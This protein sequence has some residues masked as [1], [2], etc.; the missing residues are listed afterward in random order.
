[1]TVHA[2]VWIL[3]V[4]TAAAYIVVQ[5]NLGN[6][7]PHPNTGRPYF[8]SA[9]WVGIPKDVA[10]AIAALQFVAIAG[11]FLWASW[12]FVHHPAWAVPLFDLFLLASL[13]WPFTSY[14]YVR[15]APSVGLAAVASA[16][17]MIAA[18]AV[19]GLTGLTF[20]SRAPVIPTLGILMVGVVA[21]LADGIGWPAA[22]FAH[23]L[24]R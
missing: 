1:M 21:I 18:L 22:C 5:G 6:L 11:S 15:S 17:L 14:A 19:T 9:Y 12:A 20:A 2:S 8:E 24:G 7:F 3:S 23:A 4:A 10:M 16:P 13:L